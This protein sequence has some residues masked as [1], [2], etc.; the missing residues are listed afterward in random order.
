MTKK[1][2]TLLLAENRVLETNRL[3]LRPIRLNDAQDMFEYVSDA[4]TMIYIF[5]PH[6]SI[7][8][9]EEFI[10]NY[11]MKQ[12]LGFY[13]LEHKLDQKLIGVVEFRFKD[14]KNEGEIGYMLNK[15]YW[16]QG[17]TF[18]AAAKIIDFGFE[19]LQLDHFISGHDVRNDSS[20]GLLK[21]TGFLQESITKGAYEAKGQM[22]DVVNYTLTKESYRQNF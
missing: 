15:E 8:Q 18:E 17:Y 6:T 10:A 13:A 21:K 16:R 1:S 9:T 3:I 14:K 20:A 11:Y 7:Q 12:P 19:V 4:E 2:R 5:D 22:I